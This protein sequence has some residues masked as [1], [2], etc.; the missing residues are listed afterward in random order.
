MDIRTSDWRLRVLSVGLGCL[1]WSAACEFHGADEA[2]RQDAQRSV[3]TA[4]AVLAVAPD[5]Q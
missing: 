4:R 1:V 2:A 3:E 5:L